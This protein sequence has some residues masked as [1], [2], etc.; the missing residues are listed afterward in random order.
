MDNTDYNGEENANG[1]KNNA[2]VEAQ[3]IRN[4]LADFF[5]GAGK[6]SWQDEYIDRGRHTATQAES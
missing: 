2:N 1:H 6:V 4:T 5:L 3:S